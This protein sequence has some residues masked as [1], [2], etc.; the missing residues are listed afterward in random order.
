MPVFGRT[1]ST[2]TT[3]YILNG[4]YYGYLGGSAPDIISLQVGVAGLPL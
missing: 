4:A 3:L 2:A 1:C